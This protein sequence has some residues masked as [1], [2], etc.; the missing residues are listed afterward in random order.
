MNSS[1]L[2]WQSLTD[3]QCVLWQFLE[4]ALGLVA[5]D[6]EVQ[7]IRREEERGKEEVCQSL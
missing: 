1:C 6:V 5:L 2:Q 7:G 4:E 3:Y